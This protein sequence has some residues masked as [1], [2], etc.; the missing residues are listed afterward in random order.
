MTDV[1][2]ADTADETPAIHPLVELMRGFVVDWL[3]RADVTACQRIMDPGYTA[4]VGGVALRGR[5]EEYIPATSAQLHRFPGLLV[6]VHDL[7]TSGEQVALRFSEHGPA[8]ERGG[9][10]A[11]WAGIGI[12]GW[13]GARLTSNVT[14]EDYLSRRRQLAASYSD[15]VATPATAPWSARPEAPRPDAEE[16]V[17]RW[18]AG[19]DLAGGGRVSLDDGWTGQPVPALLDA[20][21]V[22]IDTFFSAGPRVA[23]HATQHGSY[24]GGIGLA[25]EPVGAQASLRLCGMVTVDGSTVS[26]HVVRDRVGLRRDLLP[27]ASSPAAG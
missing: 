19:G 18:L 10:H 8:P 17:R 2:S 7:F 9:A 1:A 15:P 5:D 21:G 25:D 16:A 12:F 4:V 13:D 11:S 23:F 22:E 26:G 27:I 3:D 20:D 24:R 6:T 14:E